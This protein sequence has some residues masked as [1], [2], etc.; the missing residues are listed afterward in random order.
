MQNSDQED[1]LPTKTRQQIRNREREL[2]KIKE[3]INKI[4]LSR[5]TKLHH[6]KIFNV[7]VS[8]ISRDKSP[9][10]KTLESS[11]LFS[12]LSRGS[13]DHGFYYFQLIET[14]P[15]VVLAYDKERLFKFVYNGI[16]PIMIA[17]QNSAQKLFT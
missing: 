12:V 9:I 8:A 15:D 6:S 13:L 11:A 3:T 4:R 10:R 14:L 1:F 2:K 17:E 7:L 16:I 5:T